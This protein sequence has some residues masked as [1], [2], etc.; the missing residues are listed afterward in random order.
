MSPLAEQ[1]S[2]ARIQ[3]IQSSTHYTLSA[4]QIRAE[5][6]FRA[7]EDTEETSFFEMI[8]RKDVMFASYGKR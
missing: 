8:L 5:I 7:L 1:S 2:G 3:A 6:F 4:C